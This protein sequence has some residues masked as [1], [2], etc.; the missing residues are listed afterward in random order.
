MA[1]FKGGLSIEREKETKSKEKWG[2]LGVLEKWERMSKKDTLQGH[3][4][5]CPPTTMMWVSESFS[6]QRVL[7]QD[8][9]TMT[10]SLRKPLTC[11]PYMIFLK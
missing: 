9:A 7:F 8:V 5:V 3:L 2:L 6:E 11:F 4:F 1:Q 10:G